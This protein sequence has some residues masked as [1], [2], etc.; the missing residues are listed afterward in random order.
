MSTSLWANTLL[1][2]CFHK[3]SRWTRQDMLSSFSFIACSSSRNAA[4]IVGEILCPPATL[5]TIEG[6]T[7]NL[8]ATLA[9]IP[10]KEETTPTSA[11][12]EAVKRGLAISTP[13]KA[14]AVEEVL[15]TRPTFK[16]CHG[17]AI[18]TVRYRTGGSLKFISPQPTTYS[19]A[20]AAR[21][22]QEI[23]V[24]GVQH[25]AAQI[26]RIPLSRT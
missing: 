13:S 24:S 5:L 9:N 4:W 11:R 10:L 25:Q 3:R 14:I 1:Q 20:A 8:R 15:L 26:V 12:T 23:T 19:R 16:W 17:L 2:F 22:M 21:R 18:R 7:F 6:L